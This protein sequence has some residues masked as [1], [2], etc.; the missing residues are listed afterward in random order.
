MLKVYNCIADA[1]DL[2]LVGLAA[3][4]CILAS[5]AAINLLRHARK[6]TG[7]MR[8]VWLGI[9]ADI[10]GLRNLGDALRRDAG[11]HPGTSERLQYR[12]DHSVAGRR[13]LAHR[14]WTFRFPD[15]ELA[16]RT[17]DRR[18]DRRGR[19]RLD[20]LYRHGGVRNR[21]HH[22]VGSGSRHGVDPDCRGDRSDCTSCRPA[23][24]RRE[25]ENRRR[26]PADAR[27]L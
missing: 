10:D 17:V 1:H 22:L 13:H 21:R 26:R 15:S 19:H 20:A 16:P 14:R 23:R 5:F 2:K 25:M 8:L 6:S 7:H 3:F 11:I 18:R 24:H 12:L 9:S 4:I 27:D